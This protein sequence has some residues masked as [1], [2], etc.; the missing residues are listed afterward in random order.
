[1]SIHELDGIRGVPDACTLPVAEQPLRVAEFDALF[2]ASLR[3]VERPDATRLLLRLAAGTLATAA[4]LAGREA[5]CCSFFGFAVTEDH[6][7]AVVMEVTVP[8][9]Q[10][11][12]LDAVADLAGRHL[13]ADAPR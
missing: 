4:D 5:A 13:H 9:A 7:G 1:M 2:A 10:A 12:V 11:G 8:P 6:T 3:A